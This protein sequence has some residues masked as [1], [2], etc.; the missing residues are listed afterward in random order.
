MYRGLA[1]NQAGLTISGMSATLPPPF[2]QQHTL[3]TRGAAG[4]NWAPHPT[5]VTRGRDSPG[6]SDTLRFHHSI[7]GR[8]S[9]R[10]CTPPHPPGNGSANCR[11]PRQRVQIG[12]HVRLLRVSSA[13]YEL[14]HSFTHGILAS[15]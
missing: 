8:C 3:L 5:S 11:F 1:R 9:C 6:R 14:P 2:A 13:Q 4:R 12:H 15:A 7:P 10:R